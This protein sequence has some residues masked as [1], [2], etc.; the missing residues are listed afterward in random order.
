MVVIQSNEAI[1]VHSAHELGLE[2]RG[3]LDLSADPLIAALR[4]LF[5]LLEAQLKLVVNVVVLEYDDCLLDLEVQS[6]RELH[7][8]GVQHGLDLVFDVAAHPQCHSPTAS[9]I[10]D[11]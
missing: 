11:R 8:E 5:G 9:A 2:G 7:L 10:S 3:Q 1:V 6:S 4:I